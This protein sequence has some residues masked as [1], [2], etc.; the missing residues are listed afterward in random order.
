MG[1]TPRLILEKYDLKSCCFRSSNVCATQECGQRPKKPTVDRKREREE[2][3][4]EAIESELKK[5]ESKMQ[6]TLCYAYT[7]GQ[8]SARNQTGI[9]ICQNCANMRTRQH[10]ST[11]L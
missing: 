9:C 3:R 1:Y 11:R 10:S 6:S 7:T 2:S 4:N 8:E 5:L